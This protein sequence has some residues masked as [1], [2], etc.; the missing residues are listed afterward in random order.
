MLRHPAPD[1]RVAIVD[2]LGLTALG[3]TADDLHPTDAPRIAAPG[4]H[5]CWR[6]STA[7]RRCSGSAH[8]SAGGG[9]VDAGPQARGQPVVVVASGDVRR[10]A[11]LTAPAAWTS[12]GR[13]VR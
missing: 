8:T 7:G 2:A 13:I 9:A 4:D 5:A 11:A 10:D 1:E 6:W 3:L 12:G